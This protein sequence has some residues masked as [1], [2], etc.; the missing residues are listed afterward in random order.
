[1]CV[2]LVR[3]CDERKAGGAQGSSE[4]RTEEGCLDSIMTYCT[5]QILGYGTLLPLFFVYHNLWMMLSYDSGQVICNLP[6]APMRESVS[7][8]D[9]REG[10]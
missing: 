1:M 6:I 2:G 8:Y 5:K 9:N 10:G 4:G 3:G 7:Y